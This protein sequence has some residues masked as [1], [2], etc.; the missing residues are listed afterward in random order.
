MNRITTA[1]LAIAATTTLASAQFIDFE[2]SGAVG[3]PIHTAFTFGAYEFTSNHFHIID[4]AA[5]F[6]GADNGTDYIGHEGAG[7]GSL[8]TMARTDAAD[9]SIYGVSAAELWI[10]NNAS[11]PN[12]DYVRVT[13]FYSGGGSITQLLVLDGIVDGAGGLADF[14]DFTLTGF[15]NLSSVE[16]EGVSVTG[17]EPYAFGIDNV[18][19]V[20]APG[21]AALL[22]M[23]GLLAARRRR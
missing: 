6:G 19:L 3:N 18:R 15:T 10:G 8:I 9:F 22:G 7:L 23:G 1:T 5:N 12:A 17:A 13:G 21:A 2:G 4:D 11:Y 14:Q 16:F 20:P